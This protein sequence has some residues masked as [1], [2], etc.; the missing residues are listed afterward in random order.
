MA[1]LPEDKRQI[2]E[3][4]NDVVESASQAG[5]PRLFLRELAIENFRAIQKATFTF[6][7]GLNVII[8]ANNAAKTAV[9]DGL[10]TIFSV[11]TFE[12]KEDFIRIRHTDIHLS[13]EGGPPAAVTVMFTA[14]LLAQADAGLDAQFYEMLCPG[15]R[16]T[17]QLAPDEVEYVVLRFRYQATFEY[18]NKKRRYESR[19]SD[20]L[21]GPKLENRVPNEVLDSL[22]AV[23][24][25]PLRDLVND[26]A[27]VGAEIE[28]LLLSHTIPDKE[29]ARKAI[30]DTLRKEA[31]KLISEVTDNGHQV[32]AGKSLAA[33]AKPYQI[34]EG[35]LSFSPLGL[36]DSLFSAL[37]PMFEHSLHGTDKLPLSSN[38]L[39]INQLIYA[40]IV[41]SRR[42]KVDQDGDTYTFY[43]IEEP[44]AHLHPQMQDSFFHAL[45]EIR[46]HQI[47]VTS[48][49]PTITA[50]ADLDRI[51][52]MQRAE[53]AGVA[54]PLHLA[55]IYADR[56]ADRRYLHKFL[57]VTRSQLL[58]ARGAV[59][60]EGVTEALL[61]QRFSE[62]LG[63][64]LRDEA[65]EV[66]II[67]SSHGFDHFRPL[68]DAPNDVYFRAVFITDGDEDRDLFASDED[69]TNPSIKLDVGLEVTGRSATATGYGTLE[70]GLL[71]ASL[72]GGATDADMRQILERAMASAAPPGVGDHT[73]KFVKDFL[74]HDRPSLAY[75]KMKAS[76]RDEAVVPDTDWYSDWHTNAHFRK[77]KSDFAYHLSEELQ[78]LSDAEATRQFAVPQ[79]IKEAIEY[80]TGTAHGEGS[81][82]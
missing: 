2:G 31:L 63:H 51:I 11:G 24:L 34:P 77:A 73:D 58:F 53:P 49:S 50:K 28:R 46:D 36:S 79:Y 45:N 78:N 59:F 76:S 7:P 27:K 41:L 9:I 68:F 67:D 54:R 35:S 62:I 29:E 47:F 60:V 1:V 44:E 64:N 48:H 66:V 23:Y 6:Q 18:S 4:L 43:L 33:Y 16:E 22:R 12:K 8:G 40:S 70:F 80:V 17:V 3:A 13:G 10:R 72:L 39:G 5:P 20:L 37:R 19:R 81:P 74:D 25:A 52:V 26:G 38:G 30:P 75:K 57:D 32:A 15:E 82:S 14:K 55:T 65:I 56:A 61:I 71:R 42:G 21:G 69:I